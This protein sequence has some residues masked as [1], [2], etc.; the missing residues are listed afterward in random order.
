MLHVLISPEYSI[1]LIVILKDIAMFYSY[2][3]K[4]KKKNLY[5]WMRETWHRKV[6]LP[7]LLLTAQILLKSF[8]DPNPILVER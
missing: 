4:K 1:Q 2:P 6:F 3:E 8:S 7:I 5:E